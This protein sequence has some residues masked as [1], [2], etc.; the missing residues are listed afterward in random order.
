MPASRARGRPGC[1]RGGGGLCERGRGP[2]FWRCVAG[3]YLCAGM[4]SRLLI[5]RILWIVHHGFVYNSSLAELH[6]V[7]VANYR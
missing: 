6:A 1:R 3:V 5:L 4:V 2:A 7:I